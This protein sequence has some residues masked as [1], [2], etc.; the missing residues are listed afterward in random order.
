MSMRHTVTLHHI[1]TVYNDMFD[2]MDGMMQ[3]LARKKTP[4]KEDWF[5]AVKLTRQKLSKYY[6][7]VT[8]MM[9][10]LLISAHILDP[11]RKLQ[12]FRK[13]DDGMDINP[14]AETPHTTQ[15]EEAFLKYVEDE[16]CARH[17]RVLVNKHESLPSSN[18]IPS[19]TGSGSSQSSFDPY[20]LPSDD[21]KYLTPNNVA[22]TTPKRSDCPAHLLTAARLYLN[23]PPAAPKHWGQINP[24]LSDYHSYPMEINS[25]L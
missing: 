24:N 16:Y 23:S 17:R 5:F 25:T 15:Y 1:I 19:A 18:H 14:Q 21:E 3:A 6:T 13:W 22:E 12:S 8:P 2:H 4:W 10:I 9:G 20:D 7:E 11:C